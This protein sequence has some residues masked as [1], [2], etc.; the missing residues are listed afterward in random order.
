MLTTD[1]INHF[2]AL[3]MLIEM[4]PDF[5]DEIG[6]LRGWQART[7]EEHVRA[8]AFTDPAP[9]LASYAALAEPLRG[10]FDAT[11]QAANRHGL[12]FIKAIC[13][14]T[15]S[16]AER[17]DLCALGSA[18]MHNFIQRLTGLMAGAQPE[19][20]LLCQHDAQAEIDRILRMDRE[21]ADALRTS[22]SNENTQT[23]QSRR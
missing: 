5:P 3:A 23:A 20:R 6:E 18:I 9:L 13:D 12:M 22:A 10:D 19:D 7:Y 2:G 1:Y 21:S 4:A 16:D 11:M 15:I 17:R 8:I 14:S